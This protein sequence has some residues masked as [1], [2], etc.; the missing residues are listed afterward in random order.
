MNC[1]NQ[2]AIS[3]AFAMIITAGCLFSEVS[4]QEP[5]SQSK[6]IMTFSP[7]VQAS[8]I[9]SAKVAEDWLKLVDQGR[10]ADSWEKAAKLF[11]R[12]I[13]KSGWVVALDMIRKPLGTVRSRKIRDQKPAWNPKGLPAGAYMVLDYS[14]EF[15]HGNAS[16]EQITMVQESDKNWKVLTYFIK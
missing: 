13:T 5:N 11:Q 7:E 8:M 3:F 10:Y 14:T 2:W 16:I 15:S 4:P 1:M 12:T 9:E 6:A